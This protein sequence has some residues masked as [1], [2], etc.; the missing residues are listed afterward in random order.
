MQDKPPT[1]LLTTAVT[2][3]V[4]ATAE[5]LALVA[6][7]VR[8]AVKSLGHT[9]AV[10][11]FMPRE[12]DGKEPWE[13]PKVVA[14][15]GRVCASPLFG[16]LPRFTVIP[17]DVRRGVYGQAEVWLISQGLPAGCA[18]DVEPTESMLRMFEGLGEP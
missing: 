11:E 6:D 7:T 14:L 4:K 10:V 1:F 3:S 8:R 2:L 15:C 17:S 16:Y 9:G 5:D 12:L 13:C 18:K